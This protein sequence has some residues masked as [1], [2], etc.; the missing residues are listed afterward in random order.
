MCLADRRR[1]HIPK[2]W[3]K[4]AIKECRGLS[5]PKFLAHDLSVPLATISNLNVLTYQRVFHAAC[6]VLQLAFDLFGPSIDLQ[7]GISD[8]LADDLLQAGDGAVWPR[9]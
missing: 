8:D 2:L 9:R 7:L 3:R 5:G 4:T 6:S 1:N